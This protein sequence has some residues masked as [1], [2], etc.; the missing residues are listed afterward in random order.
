MTIDT[1]S[2]HCFCYQCFHCGFHSNWDLFFSLRA[3]ISPLP[4][5]QLG[6]TPFPSCCPSPIYKQNCSKDCWNIQNLG[7]LAT[8]FIHQE[9][10]L[11]CMLQTLHL[12][13]C[14]GI[15][16]IHL[17]FIPFT[18]ILAAVEFINPNLSLWD[19]KAV[20]HLV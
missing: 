3:F 7:V 8:K 4:E 5:S 15:A 10:N 1:S 20:L 19:G 2:K 6:L 18:L 9:K 17:I 12:P 14:F 16:F 13:F 11:I